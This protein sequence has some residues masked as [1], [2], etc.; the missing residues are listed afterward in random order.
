MAIE[1]VFITNN[2][3][4]IQDEVLAHRLGLIPI[5]VDPR[6]FDFKEDDQEETATN[7]VRFNMQIKCEHAQD[8]K[9]KTSPEVSAWTLSYIVFSA[10]IKP[11]AAQPSHPTLNL[12]LK[13]YHSKP[14]PK[15]YPIRHP[16]LA[17]NPCVHHCHL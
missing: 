13:P 5:K 7:S 16:F 1:K 8:G 4:I 3:S 9:H 11:F 14:Y 15:S 12:A 6:K 2:T 17:F 10:R